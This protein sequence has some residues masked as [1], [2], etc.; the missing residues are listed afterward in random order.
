MATLNLKE[1]KERSKAKGGDGEGLYVRERTDR[2]DSCQSKG[3]SRLKS[4]GGRLKCY[5]FQF[6]DHLKKNC[7]KNDRKKSTGYVNKDDQPSSS[8]SIY[9]GPE[10]MTV[11]SVEALLD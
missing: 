2:R 1:I 11:M 6:K 5:I 8:G 7:P 4:Q 3:K 10:V 9:D